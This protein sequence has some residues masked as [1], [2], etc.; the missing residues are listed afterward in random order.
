MDNGWLMHG[1]W[2][3]CFWIGWISWTKGFRAGIPVHITHGFHEKNS[4]QQVQPSTD[5]HRLVPGL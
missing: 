3:M 2:M 4:P 5:S 1:S